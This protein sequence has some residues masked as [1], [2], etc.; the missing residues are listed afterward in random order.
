MGKHINWDFIACCVYWSLKIEA[1]H[2]SLVVYILKMMLE[3]LGCNDVRCVRFD[4]STTPSLA[5]LQLIRM[6]HMWFTCDLQLA[7]FSILKFSGHAQ[8]NITYFL[9]SPNKIILLIFLQ[10]L[11]YKACTYCIAMWFFKGFGS[12]IS[13]L[14]SLQIFSDG[15]EKENQGEEKNREKKERDVYVHDVCIEWTC[16]SISWL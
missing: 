7:K 6:H 3:T 10:S 2:V 9:Q 14:N 5:H 11:P 13:E 15:D 4:H 8:D 12:K 1:C 16:M